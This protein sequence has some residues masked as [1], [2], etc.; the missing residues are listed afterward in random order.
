M[1][2]IANSKSDASPTNLLLGDG[3]PDWDQI[4]FGVFCSRCGYNLYTL[5][6][7]KC[8]E[9]GLDFNWPDVLSKAGWESDFLF[10]HHWRSRPVRSWLA[11][12]FRGMRPVRFWRT[13]SIHDQISFRPLFFLLLIAPFVSL[14][15]LLFGSI[16]LSIIMPLLGE[17]FE[18]WDSNYSRQWLWDGYWILRSSVNLGWTVYGNLAWGVAGLTCLNLAS[19]G[20]LCALRQTAIRFNV[21]TVQILRVC[22][23]ALQPAALVAVLVFYVTGTLWIRFHGGTTSTADLDCLFGLLGIVAVIEGVYYGV[24]LRFYLRLPH[25]LAM[26]MSATVIGFLVVSS[27]VMFLAVWSLGGWS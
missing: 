18:A 24:G 8:P 2:A 11:T 10:E 5:Q 15:V 12:V 22:A 25:A 16:S 14:G 20:T 4:G 27:A 3:R 13:V 9:C 21:R 26:G 1:G 23:Y 7:P 19:V 17:R 6:S